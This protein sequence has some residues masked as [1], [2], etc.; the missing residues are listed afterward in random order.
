MSI[1]RRTKRQGEKHLLPL[2]EL[3][4]GFYEFLENPQKPTD[5][6]VRAVFIAMEAK[7]KRYCSKNQ[8]TDKASL[9]FN[10]QVA[11]SWKER[12]T[13]QSPVTLN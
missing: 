7:W 12:Y 10:N 4:M 8:L 11:Q 9:L 1:A 2:G 6:Q 13:K 5:Q 3:L